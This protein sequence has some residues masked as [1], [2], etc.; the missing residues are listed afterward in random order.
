LD[1]NRACAQ[2]NT[3]FKPCRERQVYCSTGCRVAASN[4]RAKSDGRS[5]VWQSNAN[6]RK[7]RKLMTSMCVVCGAAFTHRSIGRRYCSNRCGAKASYEARKGTPEYRELRNGCDQRRR[8]RKRTHVVEKFTSAE[9]FARDRYRCHICGATCN[10]AAR[11]PDAM[12][13]TVDHL[14]PLA[15]GG[16]HT[17]ANTATACFRCN[18]VKGERGGGEQLAMI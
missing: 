14:V 11:V 16:E 1:S 10:S 6:A 2:C 4:D 17:K 18:S 13:P 15:L 12:A 9:I 5:A 8:A 3:A 7:R